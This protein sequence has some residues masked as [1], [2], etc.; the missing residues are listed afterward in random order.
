M[1]NS[2]AG[3]AS[4]T[5]IGLGLMGQA[6]S[7]AFL[8]NGHATTVWN[9]STDKADL[10]VAKGAVLADSVRHAV[11]AS[12][13]V[14][15]CVSDYDVVRE[16]LDPL[17]DVLAGRVLVNLTSG[18]SKQARE[19]AEWAA[20]RDVAYLDGAIMTTPQGIGAADTLL[21]YS[22]PQSA[23]DRH[24][25]TLRSLGGATTYL[26]ADHA[27]SSLYDMAV[28]TIMWN[29]L[30]G[31]LHA[32]ALVG[33]ANVPAAKFAPAARK[34]IATVADW[35]SGYA[36]QIDGGRYPA[37][38]STIDTH[39]AAMEH[40]IKESEFLGVNA[41]LPK[42]VKVLADRSIAD[43]HGGDS[44]AAMIEQFRKP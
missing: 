43:G 25:S 12:P 2:D 17:G 23:F 32:A 20:Q 13:L 35:L 41:E 28:L 31:F 22:G 30:N 42:F 11:T 15:V 37:L 7:G 38:D 29:V 36:D 18:T 40:L 34:G 21:F 8:K 6:L 19:I 5:V 39:L 4:V 24:E 16:L 26:G 9:R 14:I 1:P 10:L 27:L 33:T 44:Y 3:H